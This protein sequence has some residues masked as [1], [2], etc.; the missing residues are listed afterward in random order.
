M[1]FSTF[2]KTFFAFIGKIMVNKCISQNCWMNVISL[3]YQFILFVYSIS[4]LI[5]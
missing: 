5:L 2:S 3:T 4:K 1:T